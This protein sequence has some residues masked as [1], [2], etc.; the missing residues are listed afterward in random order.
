EKEED[1]G[2]QEGRDEARRRQ[3][4]R[5]EEEGREVGDEIRKEH[6]QEDNRPAVE[7]RVL[8]YGK[9]QGKKGR[10]R[11]GQGFLGGVDGGGLGPGE[12]A[13]AAGAVPGAGGPEARRALRAR[14]PD[15]P[16]EHREDRAQRE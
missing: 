15:E 10:R 12:A 11:Q 4:G 5:F 8:I 14:E 16:S 6:D 1:D 9:G 2:P 13:A 7:E 3:E